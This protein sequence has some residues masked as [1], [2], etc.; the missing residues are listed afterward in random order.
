MAELITAPDPERL[1]VEDQSRAYRLVEDDPRIVAFGDRTWLT[2]WFFKSNWKRG[3]MMGFDRGWYRHPVQLDV[4][5]HIV[6]N[7]DIGLA[8]PMATRKSK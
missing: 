3:A 1:I 2:D 8:N 6:R 7:C 5:A 4:A